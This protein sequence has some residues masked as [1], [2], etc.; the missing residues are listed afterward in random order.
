MLE[1]P[2]AKLIRGDEIVS[3]SSKGYALVIPPYNS[4][5]FRALYNE[6]SAYAES[7][8]GKVRVAKFVDFLNQ[9]MQA[10]ENWAEGRKR[11]LLEEALRDKKG[12]CK[13]FAAT[14]QMLLQFDQVKSEYI[15]GTCKGEPHAWVKATVDGVKLL[16]D[17]TLNIFGEYEGISKIHGYVESK[18]KIARIVRE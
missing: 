9:K 4:P 3:A 8:V 16:A 13:E 15:K 7:T 6:A 12:V 2:G 1:L 14:L 17:P 11:V 5:L 10:D 18:V